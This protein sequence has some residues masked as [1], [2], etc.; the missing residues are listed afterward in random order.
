M[1]Y[2]MGEMRKDRVGRDEKKSCGGDIL[3]ECKS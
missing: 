3:G 1:R 2:C